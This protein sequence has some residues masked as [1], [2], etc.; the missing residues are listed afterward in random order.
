[1]TANSSTARTGLAGKAVVDDVLV[2]RLTEWTV[3][4]AAGETAWGDSDGGAFTNR[5][6]GRLDATGTIAGKLDTGR[7]I[8][9]LFQAGDII[10][11]IVWEDASDFWAFPCALIQSYSQ[12]VNVDTKEV[13]AW[14]ATFGADGVYFRP[15]E[16]GAPA[17]TLPTS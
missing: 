4:S 2:L 16:A 10:K 14:T 6:T 9:S 15:G 13:I 7:K 3:N 1:M 12:T 5:A 11:L 17:E 8:Y